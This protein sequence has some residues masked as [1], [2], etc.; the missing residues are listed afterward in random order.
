M[1]DNPQD[2]QMLEPTEDDLAEIAPDTAEHEL[3]E[4]APEEE[5]EAADTP[6]IQPTSLRIKI[7]STVIT[8]DASMAAMTTDELKNALKFQYPE[9][10]HAAVRETTDEAGVRMVQ[11]LPAAG[12]KG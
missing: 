4:A 11:W 12:R 2:N 5:E 8:A 1:S 6:Q 9:V 7:G 3:A 10:E